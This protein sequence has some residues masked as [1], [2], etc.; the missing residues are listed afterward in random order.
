MSDGADLSSVSPAQSTAVG[1]GGGQG[2]TSEGAP[3]AGDQVG[4]SG[5]Q[6]GSNDNSVR[7]QNLQRFNRKFCITPVTYR[8]F[9]KSSVT[10]PVPYRSTSTLQNLP[11]QTTAVGLPA[12]YEPH[13]NREYRRTRLLSGVLSE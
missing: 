6:K 4:D 7:P 9:T 1:G 13:G 11:L 8:D 12:P 10:L 5:V 3:V 2:E